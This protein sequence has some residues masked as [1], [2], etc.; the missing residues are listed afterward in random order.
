MTF[1][2]TITHADT[3]DMETLQGVTYFEAGAALLYVDF[4]DNGGEV[5]DEYEI[6][7]ADAEEH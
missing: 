1:S 4:E 2:L 6:H 7:G 5:Y 3:D